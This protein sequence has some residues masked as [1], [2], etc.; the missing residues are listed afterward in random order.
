MK[1]GRRQLRWFVGPGGALLLLGSTTCLGAQPLAPVL[2]PQLLRLQLLSA[3][4]VVEAE[5]RT[6]KDTTAATGNTTDYK[7]KSLAP[8]AELTLDGSLYHPNLLAFTLK[9][10]LGYEWEKIQDASQSN[11]N[12]SVA[13]QYYDA[14]LRLLGEKPYAATLTAGR[15]TYVREYDFFNTVRGTEQRYGASAG[16]SAGP[17]PFT[18]DAQHSDLTDDSATQST[19]STYDTLSLQAQNRRQDINYTKLAYSYTRYRRET[20][21]LNTDQGADHILQLNDFERFGADRPATLESR[22][23]YHH[24]DSEDLL[25]EDLLNNG[26]SGT[27][28]SSDSFN[29]QEHFE[30]AHTPMFRSLYDYSY[31]YFNEG[32]YHNDY[33]R[34]QV[35]VEHQLYQSLTSHLDVHGGLSR[36]TDQAADLQQTTYGV[37]LGES[38]TKR[39][40][41][42][43][44][45]SLGYQGVLDRLDNR[46]P[47]G[48]STI[49]VFHERQ[50]LNDG[51]VAFLNLPQVDPV[52]IRVT[53]AAGQIVYHELLDYELV[54][55]G[56]QMEI[57]RVAG[58]TIPNGAA[59]LVDYRAASQPVTSGE[60]LTDTWSARLDLFERLIGLYARRIAS[61]SYGEQWQAVNDFTDQT[62]GA[63]LR[64]K[65]FGASAEYETY[66]SNLT[67]YRNKRLSQSYSQPLGLGSSLGLSASEVWIDFPD[68]DQQR[69]NYQF[70]ARFGMQVTSMLAFDVEGGKRFERGDQDARDLTTA[71]AEVNFQV[72]DLSLWLTYELEGQRTPEETREQNRIFLRVKRTF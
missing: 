50:T 23:T 3:N 31:D 49:S 1:T 17:V 19:T 2:E 57:R 10:Q 56:A 25:F 47:S 16:Y 11:L 21:D 67:A 39:L 29:L 14:R 70:I 48:N 41:A 58:G 55:H 65:G 54:P 26:G 13:L 40:G 68:S 5:Q 38:Y 24:N 35:G 12:A 66:D 22:L 15:S 42:W 52:S 20:T 7:N 59:V 60:V 53:D 4:L 32:P 27:R 61:R 30:K 44:Q 69:A 72:G 9:G 33:H 63:D 28:T 64:W 71:R 6:Q 36:T 51:T 8:S 43:G 34:A 45:L 18:V 37:G 46:A 62:I